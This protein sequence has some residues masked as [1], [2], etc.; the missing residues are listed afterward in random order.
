MN[1]AAYLK[2]HRLITDGAMGTYY[3]KKYK[4]EQIFV[5]RANTE[6]P[7]RVKEI[8]LDYIAAGAKLIRTNTFATNT[9]FFD[10]M[11]EVTENIKAGYQIAEKAVAE[12]G[13]EVFIAADL[14]PI[15]DSGEEAY[16]G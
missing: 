16:I 13:S 4:D 6:A 3:Q 12:S 5:E 2:E 1:I 14:G 9:M 8:H 10:T 7:E 11:E 15:Y